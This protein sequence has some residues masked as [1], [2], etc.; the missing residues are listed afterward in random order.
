M[1]SRLMGKKRY[2]ARRDKK[3]IRASNAKVMRLIADDA[4]STGLLIWKPECMH[5]EDGLARI[6]DLFNKKTNSYKYLNYP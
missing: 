3:R 1:H 5:L 4:Q 6:F 2:E